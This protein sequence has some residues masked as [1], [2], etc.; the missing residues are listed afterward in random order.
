MSALERMLSRPTAKPYRSRGIDESIEP[1]LNNDGLLEFGHGDIENPKEWS[2]RRRTYITVVS[3]LL[4]VNAT[5]A[6]SAPSACLEGIVETFHVSRVAAALVITVFLLGYCAGPLLFAPLSEFYGRR[7][8]FYI[9]FTGYNAFNFLCGFA[10]NFASL[11][12][13]RLIT[14]T[15]ASAPLTNA[16]GVLADIWDPIRRANAMALFSM[17]TFCGPAIGP[18]IAGFLQLTM[19]WRWW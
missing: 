3:V 14:G 17:M 1:Q 19:N 6:S 13:G 16:P 7:W 11:L 2:V 9:T 4:V 18:V 15:F 12:I 10:P 8:V 5:F